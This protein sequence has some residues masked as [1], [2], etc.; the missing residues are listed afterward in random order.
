MI[1]YL[2]RTF[3]K[4]QNEIQF[5]CITKL[6]FHLKIYL[7]LVILTVSQVQPREHFVLANKTARNSDVV[8]IACRFQHSIK[9]PEN[10]FNEQINYINSQKREPE[11]KNG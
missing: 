9:T 1:T 7:H 3:K 5:E 6:W 8:L 11:K 10:N 4:E 2:D